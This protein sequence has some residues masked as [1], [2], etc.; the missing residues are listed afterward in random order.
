MIEVNLSTFKYSEN[1]RFYSDIQDTLRRTLKK[2]EFCLLHI[3]HISVQSTTPLQN[4]FVSL[5]YVPSIT[6]EHLF[7]LSQ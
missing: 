4:T 2:E 6:L 3:A 5:P 1:K 7:L